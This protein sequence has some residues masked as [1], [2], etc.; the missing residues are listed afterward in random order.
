M[1]MFSKVSFSA[2]CLLLAG[3][4]IAATTPPPAGRAL[5]TEERTTVVLIPEGRLRKVHLARPD[6]IQYPIAVEICC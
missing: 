2:R 3:A 4:L 1:Q 5:A 6:L